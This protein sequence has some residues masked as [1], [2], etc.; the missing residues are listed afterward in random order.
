MSCDIYRRHDAKGVATDV[1]NLRYSS[2]YGTVDEN[3]LE[4]QNKTT[5]VGQP[6]KIIVVG[7]TGGSWTIQSDPSFYDTWKK[8]Q[9]KSIKPGVDYLVFNFQNGKHTV[10]EVST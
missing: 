4:I 8:S 2:V 7:G 6:F 10:A 9:E 3:Q 5:G 1:E